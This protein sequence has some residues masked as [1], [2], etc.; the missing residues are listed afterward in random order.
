MTTLQPPS[1]G[2]PRATGPTAPRGD[3]TGTRPSRRGRYA[4]AVTGLSPVLLLAAML[5]HPYLEDLQNQGNVATALTADTTR[6]GLSHLTIGLASALVLVAF[7]EV[8]AFLRAHGGSPAS[9]IGVP[10]VVVGSTLFVFLPAM[11]IAMLAVHTSG[12]DV[13][14]ALLELNTWFRPILVAAAVCFGTGAVL[15]AR[16]VARSSA[17]STTVSWFVVPALLVA[18]ASRFVPL[19]V[20][21][22]VGGA[23]LVVALGSLALVM[24]GRA[25]QRRDA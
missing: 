22:Y 16:A 18:A 15:F 4:V 13:A 23:A 8:D 10:F 3:P 25:P 24:A 20:S 11:E 9:A 14:A 17:V 19:G 21:L 2:S 12:G 7:L 6:W 1:Q 5:Y